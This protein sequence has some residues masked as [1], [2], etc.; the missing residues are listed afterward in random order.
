MSKQQK[1]I[2]LL[3]RIAQTVT[4]VSNAR[5]AA[6]IVSRS[7]VLAIGINKNKSHP[8]QAKFSKHEDAILIHA[9][10]DA[11]VNFLR[12]HKSEELIGKD[13]YVVRVIRS[14]ER[15]LA[16]PCEGCMRAILSFGIKRIF[17]SADSNEVLSL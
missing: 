7:E 1:I 13:I 12:E 4:P 11:I 15:A 2:T 14:G 17:Y 8:L 3:Q 5:I 16:R 9:E 6:A 10:L